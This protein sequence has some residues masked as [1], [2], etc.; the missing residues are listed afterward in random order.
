MQIMIILNSTHESVGGKEIPS[1]YL[2]FLSFLNFITL[3]VIMFVPFECLYTEDSFDHL[4]ALIIETLGGFRMDR[5][6]RYFL[7]VSPCRTTP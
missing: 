3:D 4:H 6:Q 7:P 1:P 5:H 2:D